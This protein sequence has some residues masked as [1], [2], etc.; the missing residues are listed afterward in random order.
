MKNS[1]GR[2]RS[3]YGGTRKHIVHLRIT[4]SVCRLRQTPQEDLIQMC[5]W[6]LRR[7][8]DCLASSSKTTKEVLSGRSQP[9]H[10]QVHASGLQ[11]CKLTMAMLRHHTPP[12][13]TCCPAADDRRFLPVVNLIDKNNLPLI[14][15]NRN[16]RI[17]SNF[18]NCITLVLLVQKLCSIAQNDQ[19]TMEYH[20]MPFERVGEL[21]FSAVYINYLKWQM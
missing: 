19:W 13:S 18:G 3:T 6:T 15:K 14:N 7:R 12:P 17:N 10:R 4:L 11:A 5:H 16:G 2:T 9:D 21:N 1:R 20:F 8:R